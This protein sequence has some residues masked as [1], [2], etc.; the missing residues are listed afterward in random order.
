MSGPAVGKVREVTEK[1]KPLVYSFAPWEGPESMDANRIYQQFS[2]MK[3]SHKAL[4][5]NTLWLFKYRRPD[6]NRHGVLSSNGF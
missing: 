4:P 2:L 3:K 6:S 5:G 1:E